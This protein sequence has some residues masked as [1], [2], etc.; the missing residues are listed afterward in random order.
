MSFFIGPLVSR[1]RGAFLIGTLLFLV[2]WA[3]GFSD[4]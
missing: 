4:E 2:E 3:D 1:D